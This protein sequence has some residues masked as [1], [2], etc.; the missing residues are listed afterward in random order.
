VLSGD[1]AGNLAIIG[2]HRQ[3]FV[4]YAR[5]LDAQRRWTCLQGDDI[6]A[7]TDSALATVKDFQIRC[8]LFE[9]PGPRE[10][11]LAHYLLEQPGFQGPEHFSFFD[12]S[13]LQEVLAVRYIGPVAQRMREVPL[14]S[15][16]L[17]H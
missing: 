10:S 7:E 15:P 12:R 8:V 14:S 4:Y 13:E 16:L 3:V 6:F 9:D 2:K 1:Q 5:K 11:A 17:Q